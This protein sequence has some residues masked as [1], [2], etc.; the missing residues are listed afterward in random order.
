MVRAQLWITQQASWGSFLAPGFPAASPR[1][2]VLFK[3]AHLTLANVLLAK[4][5]HMTK[6]SPEM[7]RHTVWSQRG[8]PGNS[9]PPTFQGSVRV[10]LVLL[11][12]T[13]I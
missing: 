9:P 12:S 3:S 8:H 4:G 11:C 5:S 6:P 10:V 7:G 13:H 1:W 2:E